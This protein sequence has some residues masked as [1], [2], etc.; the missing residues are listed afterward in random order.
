MIAAFNMAPGPIYMSNYTGAKSANAF[1]H[2]DWKSNSTRLHSK[3]LTIP[4]PCPSYARLTTH[5]QGY[6]SDLGVPS[7]YKKPAEHPQVYC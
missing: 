2:M 3:S 7:M 4:T 1:P 6:R 5:A